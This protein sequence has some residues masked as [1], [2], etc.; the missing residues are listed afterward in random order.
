MKIP[1]PKVSKKKIVLI[2]I[3]IILLVAGSLGAYLYAFKGKLFGW[4]PL[5]DNKS[6]GSSINYDKPTKEQK[7]T[8]DDTKKQTVTK[9]EAKP[10]TGGSDQTPAPNPQPSGKS[11]VNMMISAANQ[12]GALLQVRSLISTVTNSGTCTITLTKA[13]QTVAKTAGVQ[14]LASDSTCQG[15]DIPTSELSPGTWQVAL[16]FENNELQGDTS[17]A[18]S[19][20]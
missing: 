6:K 7:Q 8:G 20:Q 19:V 3:V 5:A 9:E 11:K 10:N 18:V 1:T 12:N 17:R 2:I 15:F 14:A 4:S 16:H 13:G